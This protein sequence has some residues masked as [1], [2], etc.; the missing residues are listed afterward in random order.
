MPPVLALTQLRQYWDGGSFDWHGGGGSSPPAPTP[1]SALALPP[2][3]GRQPDLGGR[4]VRRPVQRGPGAL[5]I[6][7]GAAVSTGLSN[8]VGIGVGVG[9]T[10]TT[11]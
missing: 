3:R 5:S 10:N 6:G 4:S 9:F 1:R 11:P 7:N 2:P 8:N